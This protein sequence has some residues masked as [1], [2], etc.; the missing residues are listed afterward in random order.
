MSSNSHSNLHG[1]TKTQLLPT[2]VKFEINKH[3]LDYIA[4]VDQ[5]MHKYFSNFLLIPVFISS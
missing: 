3:M 1:K 2:K 5:C 4:H